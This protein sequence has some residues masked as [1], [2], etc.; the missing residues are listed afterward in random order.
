VFLVKRLLARLQYEPRLLDAVALGVTMLV[1]MA[2]LFT[3]TYAL[4]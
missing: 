1:M 3:L 2:L 4:Q